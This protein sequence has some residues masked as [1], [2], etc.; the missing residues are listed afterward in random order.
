MRWALQA[1]AGK[2]YSLGLVF[3]KKKSPKHHTKQTK[4]KK[5]NP[6]LFGKLTN[7]NAGICHPRNRA[8]CLRCLISPQR[9]NRMPFGALSNP[10]H[11][12]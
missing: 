6:T 4:P 11:F 1:K 7:N 10:S 5:K 8:I 2:T 12:P 3:L 9:L